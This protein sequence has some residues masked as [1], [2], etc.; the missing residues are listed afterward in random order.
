MSSVIPDSYKGPG[1]GTIYGDS[2]IRLAIAITEVMDALG[3]GTGVG[4]GDA[5][6]ENQATEIN[7][8]TSIRDRLSSNDADVIF[9]KLNELLTELQQKTEPSNTQPVSATSLPLPTG[10]AQDR[11]TAASPSAIRLSDGTAFYKATTPTDIQPVSLTTLPVLA[12]GTNVI[13]RVGID[14]TTPGVTNL[15]YAVGN[16][17]A[18]GNDSGNPVKI[19]G[20]YNVT[21]PTYTDGKR[22]DAQFTARGGM[23][24]DSEDYSVSGTISALDTATV[25]TAGSNGQFILTGTPTNNSAFVFGGSGNSSF[26][27][28]ISGTW[29]GTLQFERSLDGGS[30]YTSIAAFAAGTPYTPST[31]TSNGNF[32][33]N[34]SASTN[35]RVR[36][37]AWTSGIATIRVLGG[38]GTG[39]VTVGNPIRLFDAV[40]GAQASIKLASTRSRFTD[41]ALV[42]ERRDRS[43]SKTAIATDGNS[44]DK[45][46]LTPTTGRALRI[47][48]LYFVSASAVNVTFK[49]GS[50][51]FTGAMNL[52]TH[53]ADYSEA[54]ALGVDEAFVINVG[55]AVA[56]NGYVIWWE[57]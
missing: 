8:L 14:Q 37:I 34:A 47:S 24:V 16:Q 12:S 11:V 33:G 46:I 6:A 9:T 13:G 28:Q 25:S 52:S 48:S 27:V 55:S 36:A 23:L 35:I 21:R 29:I 2:E 54:I 19:G 56:L 49:A 17:A 15:V 3:V 4:G 22:V 26:S 43:T 41:T 40:S 50:T 53:A 1:Y 18:N 39:T 32:H 20:V 42:V 31:I 30:T 51:A 10:A 38:A 45:T 5:T 44:G 7:R 57:V